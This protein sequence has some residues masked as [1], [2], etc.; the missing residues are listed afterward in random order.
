[1]KHISRSKSKMDGPLL[2]HMR[3]VAYAPIQEREAAHDDGES[4][5]KAEEKRQRKLNRNREQA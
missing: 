2:R 1:M 3:A 4:M 5:R